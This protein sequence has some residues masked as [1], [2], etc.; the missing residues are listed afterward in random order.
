MVGYKRAAAASL[1]LTATV[2]Q[3]L[4]NQ[5]T[6]TS[7]QDTINQALERV[8]DRV[9]DKIDQWTQRDAAHTFG[10]IVTNGIEYQL[11]SHPELPTYQIRLK[12][13]GDWCDSSSKQYSGYL[14]VDD[15]THLF[16]VFFEARHKPADAPLVMW[17]N[18]GPGC[19]SMT[20]LLFE[21]GPCSIANEGKNTTYNKY[22]WTESA[23][24]IFLDSP[25]NVGYSYGGKAVNSS[26][27]TADDVAA[28]MQLFLKRFPKFTKNEF[29]VS[30][31][32]YA[33]TYIPNIGSTIHKFNKAPPTKSW[34]PINLA[35]L[36]IGNGLTDIAT[37]FGTVPDYAC[38]DKGKFGRI[39]DENTCQGLPGK[40]STC[41]RLAGY[42]YNSASRFTCV[43]A[44]LSCWQVMGPI[45]QSGLNPYD[46]R[47][48]CDREGEDG[49]LCY[50]EMQWI[51]TYMN[52]A[53]VKKA[54][55]VA[56]DKTFQSCNM[57]INQAFTFNG[58]V[59]HNTAALIPPLLEDG[60]RVGIYAGEADF[61]CSWMGNEA[62]TL[63]LEWSGHNDFN[64]ADNKKWKL[65]GK[66][67]G[68]VRKSGKG[69]GDFAFIRVFGAGHMVPM[70]QPA[71][72][73]DLFTK[74][75]N[76]KALV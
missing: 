71:A 35:S 14:D 46:V 7:P 24:M 30:G 56:S 20:G 3:A 13:S 25:V 33:G 5:I 45:Q 61:L 2:A 39:F 18:G 41:Q 31:E 47:M 59:A 48:K 36:F 58:D 54:L 63:K 19:S 10:N 28:F 74:W 50:K 27:Q 73:L 52:Q 15:D 68:D 66:H 17:L 65:D 51:E 11:I 70:D 4:R 49:P 53:D 72:S 57:Q 1:L 6:F 43:P 75:I 16:F 55:G 26:P 21:L 34:V 40:I 67:V 64:E 22:S 38:D 69:A 44:T 32:S 76:N 42:C 8:V 12:E 62:W 29:H 60:I 9:H 23:N 37:Q